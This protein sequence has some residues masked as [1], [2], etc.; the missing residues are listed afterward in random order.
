[1]KAAKRG[2]VVVGGAVGRPGDLDLHDGAHVGTD[3]GLGGGGAAHVLPVRVVR[4]VVVVRVEGRPGRRGVVVEDQRLAGVLGEVDDDVGALGR[5]E[6]QGAAV[7]VAG[8]EGG[9][10]EV[11]GDRLRRG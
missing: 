9:D 2:A 10:V 6:D 7:D 11:P 4:V 5:A 1:M 8:V 3:P